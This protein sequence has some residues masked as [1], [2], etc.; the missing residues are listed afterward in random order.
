MQKQQNTIFYVSN[1]YCSVLCVNKFS[2]CIG[3]YRIF[4]KASN[5][6]FDYQVST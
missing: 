3:N 6:V 5:L 4:P 2:G 1:L